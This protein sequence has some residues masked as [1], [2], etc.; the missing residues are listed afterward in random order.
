MKVFLFICLTALVVSCENAP[1]RPDVAPATMPRET[2][3]TVSFTFDDGSTR[4]ILDYPAE[5]WNKMIL[6]SLDSAEIKSILFATGRDN[7]NARGRALLDSWASRGHLIGNHTYTHPYLNDEQLSVHDFTRELLRTDSLIAESPGYVKL[8][9]FPYLKEGGDSSRVTAFREVLE[10]HGYKNGYVSIDA[11]DWYV[12]DKLIA[13]MKRDPTDTVAI[14]RYREY[15]LDHILDRA[16]FYDSLA[17]ELTGRRIPHT[18]LLHHNLTSALFLDDLIERF[19]QNDWVL[20][21][22]ATAFQ[23]SIYR[24]VVPAPAAGESIVYA[25][26]KA[27]GNYTGLLRYP[28]EDSR[29]EIPL[30]RRYGLIDAAEE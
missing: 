3:P 25:L 9:R 18:L 7:N 5:E 15:Y 26:A 23:D 8:F 30:M 13:L 29:Y 20:T 16:T 27:S 10:A 2:R 12:N 4:P 24:T 21:D 14:N 17:F 11:S 19:R 22:A 1:V 6:R 28:A